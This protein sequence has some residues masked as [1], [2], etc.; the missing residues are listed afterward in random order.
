MLMQEEITESVIA[1]E[2]P[3]AHDGE[4][5]TGHEI[6]EELIR[7]LDEGK[8]KG[9]AV[10][11]AL[12]IAPARVT[13]MRKRDRQ[14]QQKEMEPLARFLKMSVGEQV[15]KTF[16]IPNFGK[17]AQGVWLEEAH[18]EGEQYPTVSYDRMRGDPPPTDLFAVTPEGTSMNKRFL[19]GTQLICR[20][21]PF[22]GGSFKE[23]DYVIVQRKAH[24]MVELTVKRLEV[25]EQGRYWLHSESSDERFKDPWMIGSP[26]TDHHTDE[27]TEILAKVIRAVQDF[28]RLS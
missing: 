27:E 4:M 7:Q 11:R 1:R 2:F 6:R 24:D 20:R 26:D 16:E 17:V 21:V 10:A 3:A 13:E 28:E 15:S 18:S 23:G 5:L 8:I 25:D 14:V 9:A 19:P 12:S 22:G